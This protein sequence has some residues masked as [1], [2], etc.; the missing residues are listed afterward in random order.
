LSIET[1]ILDKNLALR[2]ATGIGGSAV[3]IFTLVFNYYTFIGIVG[4]MLFLFLNEFYNMTSKY[5]PLKW[6]GMALGATLYTLVLAIN[7]QNQP[8][9]LIALLV[10]IG[11][12]I[13]VILLFDKN[14]RLIES[15]AITYLGVLYVAVPLSL[16]VLIAQPNI[17]VHEEGFNRFIILGVF[18]IIWSND[19]GAYFAGKTMGK[20][21][22]FE[23]ISPNKTIEGSVGGIVLAFIIIAIYAHFFVKA[24]YSFVWWMIFTGLI[25]VAG[26]FGDLVESQMKRNLNLKDS[27]SILPGHGGFLDRFDALLFALPFAYMCFLLM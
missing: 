16:L 11:V 14:K 10:F 3:L 21:K 5:Q 7:Q 19:T 8:N 13:P 2:L 15:V 27:G 17:S 1:N 18:L 6:V 4:L 24:N 25:S 22:L 20:T 26:I 9:Y 12:S 23:R